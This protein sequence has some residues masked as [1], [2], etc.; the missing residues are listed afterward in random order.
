MGDRRDNI[1]DHIFGTGQYLDCGKTS[2]HADFCFGGGRIDAAGDVEHRSGCKYVP[3][4]NQQMT[5]KNCCGGNDDRS[6]RVEV[7]NQSQHYL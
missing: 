7:H 4:S 1:P 6:I 3:R 2:I 5:T